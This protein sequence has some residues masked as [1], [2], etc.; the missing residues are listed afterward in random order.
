MVSVQKNVLKRNDKFRHKGEVYI[1]SLCD[2]K[3]DTLSHSHIHEEQH[4]ERTLKC[5]QCK[6]M[7][8]GK[9]T[10]KKHMLRHEDPKYICTEC[11]YKTYDA[12]NFSTHKS[13]KHGKV[14]PKCDTCDYNPK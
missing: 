8:R 10:L 2:F 9:N 14:V 7:G 11:D 6:Y 1:C 4:N 3:T 12:G 13:T 5:P